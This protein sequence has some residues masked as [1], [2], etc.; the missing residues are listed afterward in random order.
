MPQNEVEQGAPYKALGSRLQY[1]FFALLVRCRGIFLAKLLLAFVVAWYCCVPSLRRRA[2]PYLSR[3]FPNDG[4]FHRCL[5][6]YMLYWHL[7][8]TLLARMI[9]GIT[10]RFP[11]NQS[12]AALRRIVEANPGRGIII[13]SAHFGGWQLGL[14]GLEQFEKPVHIVQWGSPGEQDRHYFERGQGRP[15]D[16]IDA[17]DPTSAL[18]A[19]AAALR[20]G[21]IVCNM[22]DRLGGSGDHTKSLTV[23]FLGEDAHF[24]MAAY[25]LASITG[26]QLVCVFTAWEESS[27]ALV[28]AI[29]LD[30]PQG[31]SHRRP[32]DFRP[33]VDAY[34]ACLTQ[35]V[36]AYP[37]QY[38]NFYDMWRQ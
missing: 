20:R 25:A 2:Y 23:P 17:S 36:R 7:G 11:V 18:V 31:L 16:I 6:V 9:A 14:S 5:R 4:S 30:I 38:Y 19:A 24:P 22:G 32:E 27:I 37:Y 29:P 3:R 8:K 12:A 21:E 35:A 15:F 34:V 1:G 13:L 33:Y 10:G 28:Q 26:A